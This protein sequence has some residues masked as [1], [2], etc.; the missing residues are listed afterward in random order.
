MPLTVEILIG[1]A[2]FFL[3]GMSIIE[4]TRG[5]CRGTYGIGCLMLAAI[6]RAVAEIIRL[7]GMIQIRHKMTALSLHAHAIGR[8]A[9]KHP[10]SSILSLCV[11]GFCTATLVTYSQTNDTPA[12]TEAVAPTF[13]A[14]RTITDTSGRILHVMVLSKGPASIKIRRESDN[15]EFDLAL[16][17]LS[18]ADLE[19]LGILKPKSPPKVAPVAP[20]PEPELKTT[21]VDIV[22]E[23]VG[24]GQ[25]DREKDVILAGSLVEVLRETD[26]FMIILHKT[27][28]ILVPKPKNGAKEVR[29]T[30]L[31]FKGG[32]CHKRRKHI[33]VGELQSRPEDGTALR[34]LD[35]RFAVQLLQTREP[36]LER[37]VENNSGPKP[38]SS[39]HTQ[40]NQKI[41]WTPTMELVDEIKLQPYGLKEEV[42]LKPQLEAM[43]VKHLR[44][45][46][47]SCVLYSSAHL[48]DYFAKQGNVRDVNIAQFKALYEKYHG[49]AVGNGAYTHTGLPYAIGELALR[50]PT[51]RNIGISAAATEFAKHEL[52]N[53]RP[54]WSGVTL[55][56]D[57][58]GVVLIG[59]ESTNR[60]Y[61]STVFEAW[62]SNG[63]KY[64]K[65]ENDQLDT[66]ISI[67]FD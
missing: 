52:R 25:F 31:Y 65:V 33:R 55:P 40:M 58:H 59:F 50:Q 53:G 16:D 11:L 44:Q 35:P 32:W 56:E 61:G 8:K 19:W 62:N 2:L 23:K 26:D 30:G 13:P 12:V 21:D 63:S 57:R 18:K 42:S 34:F 60:G 7:T 27:A 48:A 5:L 9:R 15:Q 66:V 45:I 1:I 64:I 20:Q 47:N 14:R 36:Y 41:R 54:V 17:K 10:V 37:I 46:G 51:V 39:R 3:L 38:M 24:T 67:T 29:S 28:E 4:L 22:I 6:L 43:K 49:P